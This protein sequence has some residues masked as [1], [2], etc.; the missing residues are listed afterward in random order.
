[1]ERL[2]T[3]ND[4]ENFLRKQCGRSVTIVSAFASGTVGL[5]KS[6]AAKNDVEVIVGTINAFTSP[7]FI[8]QARTL[9]NRRLW[10]DFR[11][12]T[13]I[14]W[15]L[16]LISPDTVVIGSANFTKQGVGMGRDTCIVIR[17]DHL[18]GEY[19]Q[20]LEILKSESQVLDGE[21][22]CFDDALARHREQHNRNQA[23]LQIAHQDSR[24]TSQYR[25]SKV[26]DFD[27]WTR[28]GFMTIPLF[29][30]DEDHTEEIKNEATRIVDEQY[31]VA[32]Q[33]IERSSKRADSKVRPYRD[34]LTDSTLA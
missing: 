11:G 7:T 31:E 19:L 33:A 21:S 29:I 16:Y 25:T 9:L 30:W 12:N 24:L 28:Q 18:Y 34:F 10:V 23:A 2:H 1:M 32:E 14:H 4:L 26:P 27:T 20:Q 3:E 15:K 8:D 5:L 13:S 22:P 17:N 6:I